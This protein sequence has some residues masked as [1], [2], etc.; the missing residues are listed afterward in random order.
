MSL[1]LVHVYVKDATCW[2][3]D[4]NFLSQTV[5]QAK[6]LSVPSLSVPLAH[7]Q[8]HSLVIPFYL[9]SVRLIRIGKETVLSNTGGTIKST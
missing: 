6:N 1:R 8:L 2:P 7:P 3:L 9:Q 5:S 4:S